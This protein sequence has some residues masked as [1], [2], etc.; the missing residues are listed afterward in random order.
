MIELHKETMEEFMGLY[1]DFWQFLH[2][3]SELRIKKKEREFMIHTL[4]LNAK[5]VD[6]SSQEYVEHMIPRLNLKLRTEV[7]NY[8]SRL[9]GK[10]FLVEEG[11][12]IKIP[13]ALNVLEVPEQSYFQFSVKC[14][15]PTH[16]KDQKAV[17]TVKALGDLD[18]PI[19]TPTPDRPKLPVINEE[20]QLPKGPDE[21][22]TGYDP[23]GDAT[24]LARAMAQQREDSVRD[25]PQQ[26]DEQTEQIHENPVQVLGGQGYSSGEYDDYQKQRDITKLPPIP[27]MDDFP[28]DRGNY[29]PEEQESEPSTPRRNIINLD[30]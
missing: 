26:Q 11:D 23:V 1:I 6:I 14:G 4:V 12:L 24:R 21:R 25:T 27:G 2:I 16:H 18:R 7:Y 19:K 17:R 30:D 29:I 10:G 13:Q 5:G 9:K 15:E 8:R 3:P 20:V 22:E 28:D